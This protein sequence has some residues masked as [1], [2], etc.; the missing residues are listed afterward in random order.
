MLYLSYEEQRK[1]GTE[2]FP[3]EY[4]LV[5]E[6]HPRYS[7]PHHW[8][9]ETEL[10]LILKGNFTIFLDG[11]EL[12][13][14]QGD[15]CYIPSG[16]MHGGEG[17]D[18][19]YECID[20]DAPRLLYEPLLIRQYLRKLENDQYQIQNIFNA[21][22][23]A[24]LKCTTR[25]FATIRKKDKGWEMLVLAGLYD[26][27]GTIIQNEYY[28]PVK[29]DNRNRANM[30]RIN[31]AME[32]IAQNYDRAI[33]LQELADTVALSKQYFCRY[34][35]M[36]TGKTPIVYLNCYRI[37]RACFLMDHK[38]LSITEVALQSGYNDINYFIRCFK[39]NKGMSPSQYIK[40]S[41]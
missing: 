8:H 35:R 38:K 25:I 7:M 33:S 22:Q 24:I 27:F 37:E 34:F 21:N 17:V 1:H 11:K 19:T 26:F 10:L 4:Y 15:V 18:C 28:E 5:D 12:H 31:A 30:R 13:L 39:K 41:Y 23:P 3:L 14:E 36:V 16:M 29:K 20:F 32:Y 9:N 40:Q 6:R 2:T